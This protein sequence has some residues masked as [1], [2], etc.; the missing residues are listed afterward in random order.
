MTSFASSGLPLPRSPWRELPAALAPVL[1]SRIEESTTDMVQAIRRE[2]GGYRH[3]VSS[4]VGRDLTVAVRAAATQFADLIEDPDAPQEHYAAAFRRLGRLE[5][6]NGRALDDLHAS[7]LV[8]ARV[9]CRGYVAA[10]RAAGLPGDIAVPL[11]EAVLTHVHAMA[12]ESTRGYEEARARSG[13]EVQR[14]RRTLAGR[15]LERRPDPAGEP[16]D[17]LARRARWPLPRTLAC[18]TLRPATELPPELPGLDDDILTL[19]RGGELHLIVPDITA[20]D[21]ARLARLRTTVDGRGA[22][23]G[24]SVAPQQAWVSLHCARL[25]LRR[26]QRPGDPRLLVAADHLGELH[27]LGGAHVGRLLADQV[28]APLG[29]LPEGKA[30]RLADTL[31]ALLMSEGRTAPE[32]AAALGIHAQ[33]ARNRLRQLTAL[34]GDRLADP[35]FRLDALIALRTKAVLRATE[36]A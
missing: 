3:P 15:L 25:A 32:V 26:L 24:P 31:D 29:T 28:L 4:A 30:E 11:S 34:F 2:I 10:A 33:T 1:R 35:G 5:Y 12:R 13:D 21:G 6:A 20:A 19:F 18:V 16:L 14:N 27:L 9:A 22:V 8:G 7:Y 23:L 17:H 36:P